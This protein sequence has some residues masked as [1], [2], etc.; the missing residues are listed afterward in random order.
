MVDV[1]SPNGR[2]MYANVEMWVGPDNTP[3]KL[4]IY[5]QDGSRHGIVSVHSSAQ[6]N[7]LSIKN[8]GNLQFPLQTRVTEMPSS[9][10]RGGGGRYNDYYDDYDYDYDDHPNYHDDYHSSRRKESRGAVKVQGEGAVQ[11][12]PIPNHVSRVLVTMTTQ[13]L[14]LS[15]QLEALEG[16]NNVKV[17]ANLYNDGMHGP[18]VV[19]VDTPGYSSTFRIKNT[20]PMAYPFHV[21][22]E[23]FEYGDPI[24][25]SAVNRNT[26]SR[27]DNKGR[28]RGDPYE[29]DEDDNN[30]WQ[31]RNSN[32]RYFGNAYGSGE[33]IAPSS[34]Y[35][36]SSSNNG[37]NNNRNANSR[38]DSNGRFMGG[39]T[40]SF[41]SAG[42]SYSRFDSSGRYVG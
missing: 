11:T 25:D 15:A 32:Q 33:V 6:P 40:G 13:G 29:D 31:R 22:V 17:A 16:P 7:T 38:F 1:T 10:Q 24:M 27:F 18:A 28:Y 35:S 3:Q 37:Y 39:S 20:G 23:P 26:V 12:F 9:Y 36:S 34:A 19:I 2:N 5:S 21:L 14:P 41:T 8:Q 42:N 30:D 4:E